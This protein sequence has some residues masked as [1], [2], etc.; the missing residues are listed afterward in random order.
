MSARERPSGRAAFALAAIAALLSIPATYALQRLIQQ[1]LFPD[2]NPALVSSS[3]RV[4]MFWRLAVSTPLALVVGVGA[5]A[6]A[7]RYVGKVARALEV[8]LVA[9][10]A[11]LL[12]QAVVRP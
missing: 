4:A 12:L 2:P 9:S 5:H 7:R 6:A 3:L 1:A 10:C 8:A 11:L